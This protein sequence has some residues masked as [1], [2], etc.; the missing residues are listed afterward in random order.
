MPVRR[1]RSPSFRSSPGAA[2]E[3]AASPS[4]DGTS[5]E[6]NANINVLERSESLDRHLDAVPPQPRPAAEPPRGSPETTL[7]GTTSSSTLPSATAS[8]EAADVRRQAIQTLPRRETFSATDPDT[9]VVVFGG[10]SNA[11]DSWSRPNAVGPPPSSTPARDRGITLSPPQLSNLQQQLFRRGPPSPPPLPPTRRLVRGAV[12]TRGSYNVPL[13]AA[14]EGD[15]LSSALEGEGGPLRRRNSA[16]PLLVRLAEVSAG[17]DP[18]RNNAGVPRGGGVGPPSIFGNMTLADSFGGPRSAPAT[19]AAAANGR[20][21][22]AARLRRAAA[23]PSGSEPAGPPTGGHRRNFTEATG[24]G[25]IVDHSDGN[26]SQSGAT[27][28]AAGGGVSSAAGEGTSGTGSTSNGEG[29]GAGR[30]AGGVAG[31][32]AAANRGASSV[33]RG[34][35]EPTTA[36]TTIHQLHKASVVGDLTAISRFIEDGGNLEAQSFCG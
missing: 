11:G 36:S 10:A 3:D 31:T 4:T 19:A 15:S 20:N 17:I 24:V 6:N 18:D 28:G 30:G 34:V 23:A 5:G 13:P 16:S 29:G 12:H 7:L 22:P 2:I 25:S 27:G 35:G 33:G 9:R 32:V 26:S 21:R 14:P 1:R 8:G